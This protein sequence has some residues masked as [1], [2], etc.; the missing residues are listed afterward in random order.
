MRINRSWAMPNKQTFTIK[1]IADLIKEETKG[2]TLDP[3]PYP[4]K[5]DAL[6]FM[7]EIESESIDTGFYDPPYSLRQLKELYEGNGIAFTQEMTQ[8][9]WSNIQEQWA[10]LIKPGG[11]VIKCAWNSGRISNCFEIT[12]ILLVS[13]GGPHNDTI[14]TVQVKTSGGL[15]N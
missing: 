9:Y 3:F 8:H 2:K 5:K 1:P 14:V 11:K 12:R 6:A 10:R 15:F 7:K 13:H 4:F